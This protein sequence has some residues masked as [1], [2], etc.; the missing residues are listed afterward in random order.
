MCRC[1]SHNRM[2][3][4]MKPQQCDQ[5]GSGN[6]RALLRFALPLVFIPCEREIG[7]AAETGTEV[8]E[9]YK[10]EN[11]FS[12]LCPAP[13]K[14]WLTF[15]A[16]SG[17]TK[18]ATRTHDT[19]S[20]MRPTQKEHFNGDASKKYEPA[21]RPCEK[22]RLSFPTARASSNPEVLRSALVA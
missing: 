16:S 8:P 22:A 7:M 5:M 2:P 12:S 4:P 18:Y 19:N 6:P 9:L 14:G 15:F 20:R 1:Q 17:G 3:F 13:P 10:R 11:P 21:A